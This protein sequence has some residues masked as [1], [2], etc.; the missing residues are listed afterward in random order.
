ME[1]D[2]GADLIK[3]CVQFEFSDFVLCPVG[4]KESFPWLSELAKVVLALVQ[5][6]EY[7]CDCCVEGVQ[8]VAH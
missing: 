4:I 8:A 5:S 2:G 3:H 6:C 7:F 1:V